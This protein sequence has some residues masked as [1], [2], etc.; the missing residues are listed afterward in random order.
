MEEEDG[1]TAL[2]RCCKL[3][4]RKDC[5]V[6]EQKNDT[7]MSMSCFLGYMMWGVCVCVCGCDSNE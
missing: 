4:L 7:I 2:T 3:G 1:R 6:L 5:T